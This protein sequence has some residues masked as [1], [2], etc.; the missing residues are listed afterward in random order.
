MPRA[1]LL[2]FALLVGCTHPL[3]GLGP[4]GLPYL[5]NGEPVTVV[6]GDGGYLPGMT[7]RG[8]E[9]VT[10]R[11]RAQLTF[12]GDRIDL[13]ADD[14]FTDLRY[15]GT[16]GRTDF[17]WTAE[18]ET[19]HLEWSGPDSENPERME[20][21]RVRSVTPVAPIGAAAPRPGA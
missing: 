15:V 17:V 21:R 18:A 11:A 8:S 1:A 10:A 13:V 19:A 6:Y 3:V 14:A 2:A 12:R 7:V 9:G 5:C 16:I 4:A 20:C